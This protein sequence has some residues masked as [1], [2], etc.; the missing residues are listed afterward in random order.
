[1]GHTLSEATE[2]FRSSLDTIERAYEFMLAYAAQGRATDEGQ[3]V[4]PSIRETLDELHAALDSIADQVIAAQGDGANA[5]FTDALR[6]DADKAAHSVKLALSCERISSQL[7][8]NLNAS[9][10]LRAV[11][12]GL[13]L[14]DEA[15]KISSA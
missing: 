11:L 3:Q 5:G 7:V 8:D 15:L 9:I 10:H 14:A 4:G 6:D 1:M 13:F 12:T 2:S